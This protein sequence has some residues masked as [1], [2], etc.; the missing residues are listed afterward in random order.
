MGTSDTARATWRLS[1]MMYAAFYICEAGELSFPQGCGDYHKIG[2]Y[3][4]TVS[5]SVL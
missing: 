2:S 3:S 5:W 1:G 4:K